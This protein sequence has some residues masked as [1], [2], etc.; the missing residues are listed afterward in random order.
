M[1]F[2]HEHL[3]RG[4]AAS[5]PIRAILVPRIVDRT[6]TTIVPAPAAAAFKALAPSTVFQLP[7]NAHEAFR[8]L[9]QLTRRLPT[10]EIQLGRDFASIPGVLEDFLSQWQSHQ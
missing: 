5:M 7:G 2:L 3:P 10:Y 1:V 6:D 8:T 4:L 9:A